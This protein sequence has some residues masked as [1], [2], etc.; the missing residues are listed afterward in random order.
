MPKKCIF[1]D[2]E[3]GLSIIQSERGASVLFFAAPTRFF[4]KSHSRCFKYW[5]SSVLINGSI[6]PAILRIPAT[7]ACKTALTSSCPVRNSIFPHRNGIVSARIQ[8]YGLSEKKY[9]CSKVSNILTSIF[10]VP[11]YENGRSL[12]L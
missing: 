12:L 5:N 1:Q 9:L 4:T 6:P 8:R 11:L 2:V 7:P 10:Y 3:R